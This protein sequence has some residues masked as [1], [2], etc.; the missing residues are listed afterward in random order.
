V[1][2]PAGLIG[3]VLQM[4]MTYRNM[5]GKENFEIRPTYR[6]YFVSDGFIQLNY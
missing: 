6:T 3:I 4:K 5:K 2:P 1:N